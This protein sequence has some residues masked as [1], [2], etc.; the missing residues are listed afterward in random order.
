VSYNWSGTVTPTKAYYTFTPVNMTYF[1][2]LSNQPNWNYLAEN[3]CD[4]DCDGSI[5]YGD[6]S[7]MA[8]N[9]LDETVGNICDI[10]ADGIVNFKD[11]AKL[12]NVW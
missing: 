2:V 6:V 10:Y 7:V 1:D 5:G 4:F 3:I 11:F 9:W 8:D 12:A